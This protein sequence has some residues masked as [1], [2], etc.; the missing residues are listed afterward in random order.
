MIADK[1]PKEP[2]LMGKRKEEVKVLLWIEPLL[3]LLLIKL[4]TLMSLTLIFELLISTLFLVCPC[5][6]AGSHPCFDEFSSKQILLFLFF[7][8]NLELCMV[9]I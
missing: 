4:L 6:W 2:M 5:F 8:N 1:T 3:T 7:L 9:V